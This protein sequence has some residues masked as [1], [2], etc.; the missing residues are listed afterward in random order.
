[1]FIEELDQGF[2]IEAMIVVHLLLSGKRPL[3]YWDRTTHDSGDPTVV[4]H[5]EPAFTYKQTWGKAH[6]LLKELL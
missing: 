3:W 6:D 5:P 2:H 1:V 4:R